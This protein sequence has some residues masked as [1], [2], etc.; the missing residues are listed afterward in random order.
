MTT[1]RNSVRTPDG[2]EIV[3]RYR[4]H[5]VSHL[6]KNGKTYAVDGGNEYFRFVGD[7][8]DCIDTSL[9]SD[10]QHEVLRKGVCWGSYGESSVVAELDWIPIHRMSDAHLKAI[11]RDGYTGAVVDVIIN[12]LKYREKGDG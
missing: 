5:M 6:D 8:K 1:V 7:M 4:H 2:T 12:E 3:S 11:V 9:H 10:M